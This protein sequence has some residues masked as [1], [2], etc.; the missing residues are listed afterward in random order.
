M[1]ALCVLGAGKICAFSI[2]TMP[3]NVWGEYELRMKDGRTIE[4]A[5]YKPLNQF[6][7]STEC[8][9]PDVMEPDSAKDLIKTEDVVE[10]RQVGETPLAWRPKPATTEELAEL[11]RAEELSAQAVIPPESTI[12]IEQLIRVL[13]TE[14]N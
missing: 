2:G 1:A 9:D 8:T 7:A 14:G 10:W 6:A 13:R 5:F 4:A 11:Q 12:R 3:T